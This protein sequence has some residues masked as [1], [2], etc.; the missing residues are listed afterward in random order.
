MTTLHADVPVGDVGDQA[1][2][3][4]AIQM[5]VAEDALAALADSAR[6]EVEEHAAGVA[7]RLDVGF[8][9]KAGSSAHDE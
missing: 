8:A 2:L 1:L 6:D 5:P 9:K 7:V 4:R 3:P